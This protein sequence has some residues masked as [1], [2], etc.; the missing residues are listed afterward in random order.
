MPDPELTTLIEPTI[1]KDEKGRF[2]AFV[3]NVGCAQA[4]LAT[5]GKLPGTF[6]MPTREALS[7]RL[8]EIHGNYGGQIEVWYDLLERELASAGARVVPD[9]R[10]TFLTC[11]MKAGRPTV[12]CDTSRCPWALPDC[13]EDSSACPLDRW[14]ALQF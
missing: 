6:R 8:A 11:T 9:N 12:T 1:E 13:E 7:S 3:V 4:T 14:K 2:Q 5:A 10:S